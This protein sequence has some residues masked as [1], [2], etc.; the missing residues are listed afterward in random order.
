MF[1]EREKKNQSNMGLLFFIN[2]SCPV[3]SLVLSL[4]NDTNVY[5]LH[6]IDV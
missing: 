5:C 1:R 2:Y 4:I 6:V 3:R